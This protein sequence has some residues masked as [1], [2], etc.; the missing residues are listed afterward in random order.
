MSF[1]EERIHTFLYPA[2][3]ALRDKEG[4]KMEFTP[5]F[6]KVGSQMGV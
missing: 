1:L 3:V 6:A 4:S 2:P 5:K